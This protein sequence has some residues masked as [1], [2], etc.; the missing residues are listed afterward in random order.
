MVEYGQTVQVSSGGKMLKK[1]QIDFVAATFKFLRL[2]LVVTI[3]SCHALVAPAVRLCQGSDAGPHPQRGALKLKFLNPRPRSRNEFGMTEK[4]ETNRHVM[5]N[6]EGVMPDQ[7][8]NLIQDLRFR[9]LFRALFQHL[10]CFFSAF[11]KRGLNKPST[12]RPLNPSGFTLIELIA[13]MIIIGI[14]AAIL[15]PRFDFGATSS[16]A[17]VDG[18]AYMIASDIRYTQE[19][20]MANRVSKSIRFAVGQNSYTFPATVPPTSGLDP[21]GQLMSGVT[22]SNNSTDPYIMQFNSL[23]EPI[24]GGNGWVEVT[25]GGQTRRITVLQYTGKVNIS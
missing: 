24:V 5:L 15:L 11:G 21:S 2:L 25:I 17:S 8:L 10:V 20:A 7:V 14:L 23:G 3:W 18:A 19:C 6:S 13:V 4:A 12:P 16:T 9:R 1:I 22:I